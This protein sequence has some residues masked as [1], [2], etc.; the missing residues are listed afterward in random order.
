[1]GRPTLQ[2]FP[3]QLRMVNQQN[4]IHMGH[5]HGVTV[6]IE[7]VRAI[8]N[9]EVIEIVDNNNPYPTLH[10]IDW[11]FDMNAIINLKKHNMT[12]ENRELRL[13]VPLDPAE[14]VWYIEPVHDYDEEDDSEKIYELTA[15]DED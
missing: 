14:G 8:T 12:F 1:M 7:G 15:Q 13:I 10:G 6:D 2:W 5:L 4:I 11:A 3:I 9:F